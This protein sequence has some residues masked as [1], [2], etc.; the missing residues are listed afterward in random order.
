MCVFT[1]ER[2]YWRYNY[3]VYVA[4]FSQPFLIRRPAFKQI[5]MRRDELFR[6]EVNHEETKS[7]AATQL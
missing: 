5:M 3:C 6:G 2:V 1:Y 7:H 4:Y